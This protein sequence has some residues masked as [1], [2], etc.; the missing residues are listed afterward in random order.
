MVDFMD[1]NDELDVVFICNNFAEFEYWTIRILYIHE[2]ITNESNVW[3]NLRISPTYYDVYRLVSWQYKA[4]D[5]NCILTFSL[6]SSVPTLRR[7]CRLR[8]MST[9]WIW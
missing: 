7:F 8:T 1:E 2:T 6:G 4:S 9:I 5:T 3:V